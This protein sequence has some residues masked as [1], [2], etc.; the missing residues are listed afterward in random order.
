ML[1]RPHINI[2][3]VLSGWDSQRP[4]CA[5][6]VYLK[7]AWI[8]LNHK[9]TTDKLDEGTFSKTAEPL[10]MTKLSKAKAEG[11]FHMEKMKENDNVRHGHALER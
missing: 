11:M 2:T 6:G 4:A 8:K 7:N 10:K 1:L 3:T 5:F 9:E